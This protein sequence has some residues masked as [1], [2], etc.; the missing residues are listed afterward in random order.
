MEWTASGPHAAL[1]RLEAESEAALRGRAGAIQR[2]LEVERPA[3]IVDF[4]L[5]FDGLLLEFARGE[6]VAALAEKWAARLEAL[7]PREDAAATLHEIPV[8][9]D[10][11]DLA[12]VAACCGFNADEVIAR[13]SAPVYEVALIGFSPGFPYLAG[14]DPALHLPRRA[15]PRPRVPVGA[16]AIGGSHAGVYSVETP[17]GW[18]LLGA[19]STRLFDPARPDEE[20]F[21]LRP[22]DRVRFVPLAP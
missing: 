14:L 22:G 9:Y 21:L 15:A 10:G 20:M 11:P 2:L 17:G 4:A 12:E 7:P 5:A 8:R 19:T 3:E 18:H 13:H 1:L 16:V 6:N